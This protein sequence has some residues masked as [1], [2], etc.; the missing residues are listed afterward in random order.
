[1]WHTQSCIGWKDLGTEESRPQC[2]Q[3]PASLRRCR[4]TQS[5]LLLQLD[6]R[7]PVLRRP[8]DR[9]VPPTSS[10]RLD[11]HACATVLIYS[12]H[13][14]SVALPLFFWPAQYWCS[15]APGAA[16]RCLCF[17]A[18]TSSA[19]TSSRLGK[20]HWRSHPH[21]HIRGKD[22][23][24]RSPGQCRVDLGVHA[25]EDTSCPRR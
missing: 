22:P 19:C 23:A 4:G 13:H 14:S 9:Q 16:D 20:F 10:S 3:L 11:E 18:T 8:L 6:C 25:T 7:L 5:V 15:G 12:P 21:L 17:D 24:N 1:M 2:I